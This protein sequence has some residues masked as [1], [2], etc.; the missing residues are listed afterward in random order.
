MFP[1]RACVL[2][3]AKFEVLLKI[4]YGDADVRFLVVNAVEPEL[5]ENSNHLVLGTVTYDNVPAH[6]E[7]DMPQSSFAKQASKI[8]APVLTLSIQRRNKHRVGV[9]FQR[10]LTELLGTH[11]SMQVENLESG[12][13]QRQLH[14]SIAHDMNV[15]PD[16]TDD[17]PT[18]AYARHFHPLDLNGTRPNALRL[19]AEAF[20]SSLFDGLAIQLSGIACDRETLKM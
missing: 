9:D 12:F 17:D 15:V 10:C 4:G 6:V 7:A 18:V 5:F 19:R 1:S 3:C 14:N 20:E 11:A 13:L 8:R 2:G 16:Y